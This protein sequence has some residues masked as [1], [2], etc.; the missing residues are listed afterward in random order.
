MTV[1]SL[2][3]DFGHEDAYVGIVKGAILGVNPAATLVDLTHGIPAGDLVRAAYSLEAAWGYFP[4]GTVHLVVVD[5]GVGSDRRIVA[6]AAGGHLFLAPDNGVLTPVLAD[7]A[8]ARAVSVENRRFF[9]SPVS[10]TFHG[11]DIFAPVAGHLSGGVALDALGPGIALDTLVRLP[12]PE[13]EAAEGGGISG[14]VVTADRFGNLITNIRRRDLA[15]EIGCVRIGGRTIHGISDTYA[16]VSPGQLLALFG[17]TQRLEVSVNG[18][19][20]RETLGGGAGDGGP[21]GGR[22]KPPGRVH[23]GDRVA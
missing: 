22:Y 7:N 5:P 20:A 17:S 14:V 19:S 23:E 15:G 8:G 10:R 21:G 6:V 18:G 11:R 3:T 2:L 16:A 1:V 9:L 13:P 12:L 4:P